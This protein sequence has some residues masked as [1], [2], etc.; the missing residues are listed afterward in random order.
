MQQS[1]GKSPGSQTAYA[2]SGP[3]GR[4]A[5]GGAGGRRKWAG[6]EGGVSPALRYGVNSYWLSATRDFCLSRKTPPPTHDPPT[7][8]PNS[9]EVST[10]PGYPAG[11]LPLPLPSGRVNCFAAWIHPYTL[12]QT[13]RNCPTTAERRVQ[14]GSYIR[15]ASL[16][17]MPCPQ[18]HPFQ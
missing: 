18:R 10:T 1:Q 7:H 3:W 12:V 5:G 17:Q 13:L 2:P 15:T 11:V 8:P 16:V 6:P 9:T 14:L 4:G